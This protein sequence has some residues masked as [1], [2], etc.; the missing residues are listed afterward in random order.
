MADFRP[1]V[2]NTQDETRVYCSAIKKDSKKKKKEK[3]EKKEKERE[4]RKET[5]NDRSVSK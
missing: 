4:R 2:N 3:K 1:W 5:H